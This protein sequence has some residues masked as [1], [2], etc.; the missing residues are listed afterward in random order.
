M[1][2]TTITDLTGAR[3]LSDADFAGRKLILM[4]SLVAQTVTINT[5]LTNLQPV[6]IMQ[7]GAGQI[8]FGGTGTLQSPDA[9]LKT[10]V[11][12]STV[13]IQP[14]GSDVYTLIGD[15]TT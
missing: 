6:T 15:L 8:T 9:N 2:L 14:N 11:K 1:N 4:D 10:R 7:Y 5:G 12:F 3:V 13:T